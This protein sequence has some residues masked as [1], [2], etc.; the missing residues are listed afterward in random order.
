MRT[1]L[2]GRA[3]SLLLVLAL[4][5]QVG[6]GLTDS[7]RL[8]RE[9]EGQATVVRALTDALIRYAA[10]PVKKQAERPARVSTS[11]LA[12]NSSLTQLGVS[13]GRPVYSRLLRDALLGLPPPL[14]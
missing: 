2:S 11:E 7:A 5:V 10:R 8:V 12:A 13:V 1:A 6:V 9:S 3:I 4:A 14:A